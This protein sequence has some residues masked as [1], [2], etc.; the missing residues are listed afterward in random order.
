[1]WWYDSSCPLHAVPITMLKSCPNVLPS[2]CNI[3]Q[4]LIWIIYHARANEDCIYPLVKKSSVDHENKK[5][6]KPVSNLSYVTKLVERVA[7]MKMNEHIIH[8]SVQTAL[9]QIFHDIMCAVD[10]LQAVMRT[11]LDLSAAFD[12][13]DLEILMRHLETVCCWFKDIKI[14]VRLGI[15]NWV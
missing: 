5:N 6:F 10:D 14:T 3:I 12:N 2:L 11:L 9:L 15:L 8:H 4:P 13:V 7:V 1:M